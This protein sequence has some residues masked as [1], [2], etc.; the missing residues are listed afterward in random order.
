MEAPVF[1]GGSL[2]VLSFSYLG[3]L[4]LIAWAGDRRLLYPSHRWL[5]PHVYALALAVYCTSWTF[6]GA[7]GSA[8]SIGL[9]Y[10]AIYLGPILLFVVFGGMFRRVVAITHERKI[11]SIA[12]FVASRYGKSQRLAA[13]VTIMA[14]T[15]AVPY[16]A[17]Q[18]KAVA[19]SLEVMSGASTIGSGPWLADGA[20][21]VA[22][23]LALFAIL[24]GTRAIDA[25]EHHRGLM[26]AIAAESLVKLAAFLAVGI[27]AWYLLDRAPEVAVAR[28]LPVEGNDAFT[29]GFLSQVMLAFFAALLLPRQFQVGAVECEDVRDVAT[30]RVTF[31]LYLGV[32]SLLALPIAMAG[33]AL[34]PGDLHP[35]RYVLWLP[36]AHDAELLALLVFLGGFSAATGMVIVESVALATMVSNELVIPALARWRRL[37]LAERGDLSQLVLWVRRVTILLLILSAFAYYRFSVGF[38]NLAA[39]GLISFVAV[40][41]FAPAVVAGLYSRNVSTHGATAGLVAGFVVWLYTL[42]LPTLASV[43]WVA[44]WMAVG[45]WGIEWLRPQALFG[46]TRF[47]SITHGAFW[48]LTAN[49]L[50]MW[51]VSARRR[52]SVEERLRARAFVQPT[53]VNAADARLA[54]RASV[55]DLADLASRI[56]GETS[57][58]RALDEYAAQTGRAVVRESL[59]ERGLVQHVERLLAGAVGAASARLILTG[60]LRGTG[61]EID[62][63]AE[64]LDEAS[65]ELR[66]SRELLGVTF[67]N[68]T[69]GISVVDANQ[70]LVAWNRRYAEFFDYPGELLAVG[71]PIEDL[72]RFNA[73]RG[74]LGEGDVEAL[75]AARLDR[76]RRGEPYRFV[77]ERPDGRVIETEGRPL[78]G[79]GYLAMFSDVTDYKRVEQELREAGERLEARVAARTDELSRALEAKEEAQREAETANLEKTRILAAASHDLLQPLN[80]ARLFSS[81]LREEAQRD[82]ALAGLAERVDSSLRAAEELVDGLLDLSRLDSGRLRAEIAD[83][84]G[85]ELLASLRDQFAPLAQ[86]RGLEL[87]VRCPSCAWRSDRR[88]LRRILQNL[89]SNAMRYTSHGGVLIAARRRGGGWRISVSDTGPGIAESQQALIFGEFRRLDRPSPWG[90]QGLGLGLSI[91]DRLARLLGHRLWLTSRPGR[92]STFGVDVPAGGSVPVVA[93]PSA[94]PAAIGQLAGLK[95]L[96]VDNELSILEGMDV[97]LQRW[98][99]DV[100]LA[101]SPDGAIAQLTSEPIDV[102]LADH[103]LDAELNGIELL[104]VIGES[105]KTVRRV[106]VTGNTSDAVAAAAAVRSIPML[107]KPLKP[108]ALRALLQSLMR[109]A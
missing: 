30:A 32:F 89:L 67:E 90:E 12:D 68:I 86:A 6:Y 106:L 65:Q 25:S 74:L 2:L 44:G 53:G 20:F 33:L 10:L 94:M 7:V 59:A 46:V 73:A 100:R 21:F 15:A 50:A 66:F 34:A 5:R 56:V 97:L 78:P 4:F 103:Q 27:F 13:L 82:Q 18:F 31:P 60:A 9:P 54:G 23:L 14:L 95:V 102:V 93:P 45:P 105:W 62:E 49:V 36:L 29:A 41:Q 71:R 76:L 107:L 37:R 16:I 48:S 42:F 101:S 52:P 57:V 104:D 70:R 8:A 1:D 99:V 87:R 63:V 26:L 77:R 88:L 92:G 69:H 11:T 108:A 98:G 83:V 51:L 3:L 75:V 61:M 58:K 43:P 19:M 47:D 40:A 38:A 35:D 28:A 85:E 84:G 22:L 79:G 24:F 80:A 91:C 39:V 64:L 17:L 109:D 96:C 81:A 55:A 72:L